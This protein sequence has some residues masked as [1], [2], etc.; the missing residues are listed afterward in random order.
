MSQ[1]FVWEKPHSFGMNSMLDVYALG[2]LLVDL[3]NWTLYMDEEKNI[4][5]EAYNDL[6]LVLEV[7]FNYAHIYVDGIFMAFYNV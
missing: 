1:L 2:L 4:S 3:S 7:S 5:N 6:K